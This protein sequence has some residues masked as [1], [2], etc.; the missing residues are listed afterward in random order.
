[1]VLRYRFEAVSGLLKELSH[2]EG[3]LR[4]PKGNNEGA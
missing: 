1:M 3:S 4:S 2:V